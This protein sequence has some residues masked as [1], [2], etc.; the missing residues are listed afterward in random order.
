MAG[1]HAK[2]ALAMLDKQDVHAAGNELAT[3]L[4]LYRQ[5]DAPNAEH[6]LADVLKP[7]LRDGSHYWQVHD[8]LYLLMADHNQPEAFRQDILTLGAMLSSYLEDRYGFSFTSF[9]MATVRP[10]I[11]EIGEELIP[12]DTSTEKWSLFT[13]LIPDMRSRIKDEMGLSVPG[14]RVRD[15]NVVPS[16][17]P[18][19]SDYHILL[20]EVFVTG[21]RVRLDRKFCPYGPEALKSAGIAIQLESAENPRTGARGY[22]LDAAS[23]RQAVEHKLEVW[24]EPLVYVIQ[25]LEAVLR[26]NLASFLGVEEAQH[27]LNTWQENPDAKRLIESTLKTS[28]DQLQFSR[29]LRELVREQVPITDYIRLLEVFRDEQPRQR[30]LQHLVDSA[31]LTVKKQGA[32]ARES[33]QQPI[34]QG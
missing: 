14:V 26:R 21:G 8:A 7:M 12:E 13:K 1:L 34:L 31:R 6:T 33:I 4:I 20:D 5:I 10:I 28:A 18:S 30:G 25:H 29:M 32:S 15:L 11:L 19:H 27:L 3:A 2:L 24:D 16:P 17:S 22:W 9:D 23:A